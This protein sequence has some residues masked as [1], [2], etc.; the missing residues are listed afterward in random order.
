MCFI[1]WVHIEVSRE[2]L[3]L[4][5]FSAVIGICLAYGIYL[6]KRGEKQSEVGFDHDLVEDIFVDISGAVIS[7]GVYKLSYGSRVTDL[8]RV[9][10]GLV[11]NVSVEWVSKNLNLSEKLSDSQKVYIPFD[12]E[13]QDYVTYKI[14]PLIALGESTSSESTS[15]NGDTDS[16]INVNL[17][18]QDEL[19]SLPGIGEVT[20]GR[21]ID[22]RPYLDMENL[23]DKASIS[24][25]TSEKI[26][27]L[28]TF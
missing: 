10:G 6:D 3:L 8:L 19:E 17:A 1:V 4:A 12:W 23:I 25:I 22:N 7:P 13:V 28:V 9:S 5:I 15:N 16:L 21:I 26:K 18:S 20:A 2:R 11:D 24:S 27:N 14:S